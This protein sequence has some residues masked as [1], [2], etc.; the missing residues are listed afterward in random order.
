MSGVCRLKGFLQASVCIR[1]KG[2]GNTQGS[3]W[4]V[5]AW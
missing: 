4:S 2:E 1:K 3:E 5:R